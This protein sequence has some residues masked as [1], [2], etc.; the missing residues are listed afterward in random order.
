MRI[1][2][3]MAIPPFVIY[4]FSRRLLQDPVQVFMDTVKKE[5]K[6]LL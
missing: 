5:T 2:R 4:W 1:A 6:E 3:L